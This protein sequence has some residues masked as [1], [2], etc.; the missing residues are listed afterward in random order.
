MVILRIRKRVMVYSNGLMDVCIRETGRM[1][2]NM[3]EEFLLIRMEIK[4]RLNGTMVK[5]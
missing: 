1:V 4:W 3:E 5:E 2:S